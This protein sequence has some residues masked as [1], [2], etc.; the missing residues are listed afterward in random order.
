VRHLITIFLLFACG[1]SW[2]TVALINVNLESPI[3]A[4]RWM[5]DDK[6]KPKGG[7]LIQNLVQVKK[8]LLAKDRSSCLAAMKRAYVLGKS[9]GPWIAWNHAQCAQL[10]DQ[11]GSVSVSALKAAMERLEGQPQ[12]LLSGPSAQLLRLSYVSGLLML[13]EQQVKTDR[14]G[15]WRTLDKLQLVRNWSNAEERATAYRFAGELAFIEQN[16][17]AAHD[18]LMRSLNE[19]ESAELRARVE[20]L[21]SS[22]LGKKKETPAGGAGSE[23]GAVAAASRSTEELGVSEEERDI[24]ARMTR[25]Y[26][27]QDYISAI[28]D[29]LDLIQKFPGGR[30]AIDASD[31]V[32]DIYLSLAN[33]TEDKFRHVR[34]RT[35][36]EM[37]KADP[38][39]LSRW[40]N[41]AY[42]K[43][44]YLDALNLAEKAYE[45]YNGH[46]DNTRMALLAGEAA[47]AAGAYNEA[48]EH[49]ERLVRRHAGTQEAAEATF[50]LG[51]IEFRKKRYAQASGYLERLLALSQGKDWEYRALYWRWRSQQKLDPG[52]AEPY[53]RQLASKFPLTYYGLRA[54]A[55]LNGGVIQLA[56][57]KLKTSKIDLRLLQG[58]QLGWERLAILLKAGWFREAEKEIEFLPEPNTNEERL[59]R[60]K[61][62]AGAMRYDLAMPIL[63][64]AIDENQDYIKPDILRVIYPHDYSTWIF[65]ESKTMGLQDDWV[66]SLIR[67]ESCF[68]PDAKSP[69][70]AFGVM[71]VLPATAQELAR[72]FKLKNF[73]TPESLLNPELNIKLGTTYLG[74]LIRS[75]GGNVPLALAAYNAGPTRLRRWLNARKDL[76]N[77]ESSQSSAPDVEVWI[78]EIPWEETSFYV[79]AILRNWMVYRLLDGSKLTL[80]EP[81]W[82]DARTASR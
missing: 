75:F 8:A 54:Q 13:A 41:N 77:L 12:W 51:L 70:S 31:R 23:S 19:K 48:I 26:E 82:V 1:P 64:K 53:A 32:L 4:P 29:A 27:S 38:A 61:M 73:S 16:L 46:P 60:A 17:V 28:E 33:R 80:S 6:A 15:A 52:R 49:F 63:N 76:S 65:R 62:W 30:H 72:E 22:L 21:R 57:G 79:K 25:S 69:A 20:A 45:K 68:R 59:L 74:R 81:I 67:Q 78:D 43:G 40:A 55:E 3:E 37:A 42:A 44:S 58:E 36:K 10:K 24:Y 34:D 2:A 39:R 56:K 47:Q 5:Y 14:R 35:V 50:R 9:L 18:F 66:R 71:Q 7:A 11:S